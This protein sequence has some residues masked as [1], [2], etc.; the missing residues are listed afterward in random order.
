M[1]FQPKIITHLLLLFHLKCESGIKRKIKEERERKLLY[2]SLYIYIKGCLL[3]AYIYTHYLYK[4]R[5]SEGGK[6]SIKFS[7]IAEHPPLEIFHFFNKL[8]KSSNHF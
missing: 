6:I 8:K 2:F 3:S 5:E 7:V 4:K 1:T